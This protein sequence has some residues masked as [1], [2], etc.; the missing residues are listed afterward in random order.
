MKD[1]NIPDFDH[2]STLF[3]YSK[4]DHE[5]TVAEIKQ[6]YTKKISGLIYEPKGK[7]P[8]LFDLVDDA[9]VNELLAKIEASNL[10]EDEKGFLMK[11]AFRHYVFNYEN[12]AEYYAHASKECQELMEQSA[13][14]VIDFD[15]AL[16]NGYVEFSKKMKALWFETWGERGAE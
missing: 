14:V 10:P 6:K 7:Q 16:E 12:I 13:L 2:Y 5:E 15:S 1:M 9:K 8:R 4:G 11:A 3:D